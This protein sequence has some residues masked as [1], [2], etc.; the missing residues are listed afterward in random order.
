[1]RPVP[2]ALAL[3]AT[4][5]AHIVSR[6]TG[7]AL[8]PARAV[9]SACRHTGSALKP[10]GSGYSPWHRGEADRAYVPGAYRCIW[11]HPPAA[12]PRPF[13][14]DIFFEIRTKDSCALHKSF[15]CGETLRCPW[16]ARI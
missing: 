2:R 11:G 16:S 6:H 1:V 9:A 7:L 10:R 13:L 3:A 8:K 5:S 15:A 12:P 4:A 14:G